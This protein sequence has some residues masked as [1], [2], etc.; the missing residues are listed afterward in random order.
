MKPSQVLIALQ[1]LIA[2]GRP[3]FLWGPPGVGKSDVVAALAKKLKLELR[4]VRL[5]LCDPTDLKGFPMP[6]KTGTQMTWLPPDFLPTKGKGILFLDEL[7]LAP[8]AVRAAAFQLILTGRLSDYKLPPGWS[9]IAASNRV[10]DRSGAQTME[11]ALANRFV[12]IDFEVDNDDWNTWAM[13]N[14]ISDMTRGYMR[15]RPKNLVTEK[16]ESG[17]RGFPTPR[18]WVFVD[19]IVG[20]GLE[21]SIELDLIKGTVGDGVGLEFAGYIREHKNLPKP[22][23]ILMDPEGTPV[24]EKPSTCYALC[25]VLEGMVD[26]TN[27]GRLLKYVNRM[28][29]EFEVV[30]VTSAVKKM[31]SIS[32]TK[33]FTKWIETNRDVLTA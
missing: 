26:D 13:A 21:P 32:E 8:A 7:L 22:E 14:G 16:L 10:T 33:E 28:D 20:S 29:K 5:S 6:N 12:H 27:F 1:H 11:A 25:A 30:F 19:Q 18:S 24:P 15:W 23:R 3:A 31:D 9:I 2:V 17:M 4:D